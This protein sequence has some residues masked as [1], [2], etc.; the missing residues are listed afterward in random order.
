MNSTSNES[1]Y[2]VYL[3]ESV[4]HTLEEV[5]DLL[6]RLINM[7]HTYKMR[8]D[9][10]TPTHQEDPAE[11]CK[12][13]SSLAEKYGFLLPDEKEREAKMTK[14]LECFLFFVPLPDEE[15]PSDKELIKLCVQYQQL[16]D[17]L[18]PV[19]SFGN[20]TTKLS[21]E[22]RDAILQSRFNKIVDYLYK[23]RT[24]GSCHLVPQIMTYYYLFDWPNGIIPEAL[25]VRWFPS[26]PKYSNNYDC[27]D[28]VNR[29]V[30][31]SKENLDFIICKERG[32]H[33]LKTEGNHF[34]RLA[35]ASMITNGL[36]SANDLKS[37][38]K[39]TQL[40]CFLFSVG[41]FFG[42]HFAPIPKLAKA[43]QSEKAKQRIVRDQFKKLIIE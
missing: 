30:S 27:I 15:F 2:Y 25:E 28:S 16:L 9:G 3:N 39:I 10:Y 5:C 32:P 26:N 41:K 17:D 19:L 38:Q 20:S 36:L 33:H 37:S 21:E 6:C 4:P 22:E 8:N 11:L 40:C 23:S 7:H 24:V 13:I 31:I 43:Y 1:S 18:H 35:S 12:K 14:L 42:F 34:I 29:P